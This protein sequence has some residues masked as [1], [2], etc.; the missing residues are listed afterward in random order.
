MYKGQRRGIVAVATN[1]QMI[2]KKSFLFRKK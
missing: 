1:E 2:K